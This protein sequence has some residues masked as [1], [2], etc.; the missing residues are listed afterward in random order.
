MWHAARRG[1]Q[2]LRAPSTVSAQRPASRG[3]IPSL[4]T[5]EASVLSRPGYFRTPTYLRHAQ[6]RPVTGRERAALAA[7]EAREAQGGAAGG[8][9]SATSDAAGLC[10]FCAELCLSRTHLSRVERV[11]YNPS[12]VLI[13]ARPA[14]PLVPLPFFPSVPLVPLVSA[15]GFIFGSSLVLSSLACMQT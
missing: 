13:T 7:H 10:A 14:H 9:G 11:Q 6:V 3:S 12:T 15:S 8:I 4:Y 1:A 2:T 5:A